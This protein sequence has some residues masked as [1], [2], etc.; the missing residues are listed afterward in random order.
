MKTHTNATVAAPV[1]PETLMAATTKPPQTLSITLTA[2]GAKLV[3]LAVRKPDGSAITHATTVDVTTKKSARGM[4]VRHANFEVAR[5]ALKKQAAD[6]EKLGWTYR[7]SGRTFVP[8][9]DAFA[10]LPAAPKGKK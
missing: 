6:A 5:V 3:L 10:T 8:K 7:P 4:T 9:P 1:A 2:P